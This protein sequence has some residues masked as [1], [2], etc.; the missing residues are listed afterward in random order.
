MIKAFYTSGTGAKSYQYAL[1]VV[2]NNISNSNT[3]GY[4]AL[5]VSFSDLLYDNAANGINIGTGSAINVETDDTQG[6]MT[7]ETDGTN[8]KLVEL[9]NVNLIREMSDMLIAQRGFQLNTKMIQTADE[10]EQYANNLLN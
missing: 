2:A 8:Q 10:I 5:K 6:I 7:T 1:D 3:N 4:K 9:S